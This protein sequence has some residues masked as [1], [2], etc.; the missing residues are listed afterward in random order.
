M[1]RQHLVLFFKLIYF[2]TSWQQFAGTESQ[3]LIDAAALVLAEH[4]VDAVELNVGCPVKTAGRHGYGA[5]MMDD[6]E[7]LCKVVK[8]MVDN[9]D[10]PV[11]R[12]AQPKANLLSPSFDLFFVCSTR[13]LGAGEDARLQRL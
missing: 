12:E 9:I 6:V 10:I 11:K 7:H 3:Y 4:G 8:D 13:R 2:S 1:R 5:Y